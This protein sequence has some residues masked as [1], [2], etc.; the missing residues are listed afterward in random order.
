MPI[1]ELAAKAETDLLSTL[2]VVTTSFCCAVPCVML[3][4]IITL[5]PLIGLEFFTSE[6]FEL[7][8]IAFSVSLAIIPLCWGK[9]VHQ[10]RNALYFIPIAVT[11]L[12]IS[13]VYNDLSHL[14][15]MALGGTTLTAAHILNRK[16]IKSCC[17]SD[18]A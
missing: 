2:D 11:L 9:R 3:P 10:Q 15:L 6:A 8:M 1:Q 17:H 12:V 5:F 13:H 7:G 18:S 14:I 4:L 16:L